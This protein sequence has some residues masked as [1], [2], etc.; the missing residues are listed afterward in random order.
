MAEV[1]V[2]EIEPDSRDVGAV[3]KEAYPIAELED[4]N[5]AMQFVGIGNFAKK[6]SSNYDTM[7]L[8][9]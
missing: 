3:A 2:A 8:R 6:R 4:L 1:P 9:Y 7:R 5:Q